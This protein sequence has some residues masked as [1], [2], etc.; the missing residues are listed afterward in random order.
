MRDIITQAR[1]DLQESTAQIIIEANSPFMWL[2]TSANSFGRPTSQ[3]WQKGVLLIH[4]LFDSPFM[5]RDIGAALLQQGLYVQSLLLPGH[6][7][8]PGD[9]LNISYTEWLK[10]VDYGICDL[11]QKVEDVYL[12]G[13]SLGGTLAIHHALQKPFIKGLLLFSP[14]IQLKDRFD[15]F[16]RW[17][18]WLRWIVPPIRWYRRNPQHTYA[19]YESFAFNAAYQIYLLIQ[20]NYQLL[21][22]KRLEMPLFVVASQD[23]ETI[24]TH[25]L[26]TF[27][28]NQRHPDSRMIYYG[29]KSTLIDDSRILLRP[30]A[31]P[32]LRI[33]DFSHTCIPI[34]P[35][36]PHYGQ[37]GDYQDFQHYH[38]KVTPKNREIY[39]GATHRNNLRRHIIQRLSYNPDFAFMMQMVQEVM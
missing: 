33:L 18:H 11:A 9:L 5:L 20:H 23:D 39:L 25:A 1:V 22:K 13:F 36:N 7:T 30:S 21:A 29:N 12:A 15:A 16:M 6:G 3:R 35:S 28:N 24:A 17:H 14:A 32:E 34:A 26:Q 19:K 27:F 8:V 2:P 38:Y 37:Q 4:G 31:Y 10:A